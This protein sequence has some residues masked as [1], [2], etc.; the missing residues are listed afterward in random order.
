MT[1]YPMSEE[2]LRRLDRT[3]RQVELDAIALYLNS[4]E[5]PPIANA[6]VHPEEP[7]TESKLSSAEN[8]G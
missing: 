6:Y 5:F 7:G 8:R 3:E 1:T 2:E 4:R